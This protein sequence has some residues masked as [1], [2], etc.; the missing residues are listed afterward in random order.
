M[1]AF[2]CCLCLAKIQIMHKHYYKGIMKEFLPGINSVTSAWT[3]GIYYYYQDR[4]T[5][6]KEM[7]LYFYEVTQTRKLPYYFECMLALVRADKFPVKKFETALPVFSRHLFYF[8]PLSLCTQKGSR[9]LHTSGIY[10]RT[11][12][13]GK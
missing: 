5:W 7:S 1:R 9:L 10:N 8:C 2:L 12:C 13:L 4:R 6:F 11:Y 3:W